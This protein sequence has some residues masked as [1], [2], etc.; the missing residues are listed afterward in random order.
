MNKNQLFIFYSIIFLLLGCTS[1]KNDGTSFINDFYIPKN[2]KEID[3]PLPKEA[4]NN[5]MHLQVYKD[6]LL[7]GINPS[8]PYRISVFNLA[9]QKFQKNIE[10]EPHLFK[11][12][13]GAFY[14]H[15]PDSIFVTGTNYPLVYIVSDKGNVINKFN[16]KELGLNREGVIPALFHYTSPYYDSARK[17]LFVTILPLDWDQLN[18]NTNHFTQAVF[19]LSLK[20]M[21]GEYAPIRRGKKGILPYDLNIP[22][23]LIEGEHIYISYPTQAVVE[24]Y[25]RNTFKKKAEKYLL[26]NENFKG[27]QPLSLTKAQDEQELWN[28]R[29]TTPFFEPLFYHL[30]SRYF[31]VVLHH[32]QEL[33]PDGKKLNDG[34]QREATLFIFDSNLNFLKQQDFTNGFYGVRRSVPLSKGVLFAAHENYWTSEDTLSIRYKFNF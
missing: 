27:I 30:G 20:K 23:R 11:E 6:S 34:S 1:K 22:Y 15:S 10:L 33:K 18:E 29:I 31:S 5:Y 3:I 16:L 7:Y 4:Y 8:S 25:D 28:F 13:L 26:P 32:A 9:F 24:L 19:D 21:I 12:K 2:I 17:R 14:V